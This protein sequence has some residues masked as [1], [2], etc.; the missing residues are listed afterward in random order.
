M[1]SAASCHSRVRRRRLAIEAAQAPST[2][3]QVAGQADAS[4]PLRIQLPPDDFDIDWTSSALGQLAPANQEDTQAPSM[5]RSDDETEEEVLHE[6]E[7]EEE[8]QPEPAPRRRLVVPQPVDDHSP[9]IATEC[10]RCGSRLCST[11]VYVVASAPFAGCFFSNN[12]D[13]PK[14]IARL[15]F[16]HTCYSKQQKTQC[17][18]KFLTRETGPL[19]PVQHDGI[20]FNAAQER[21]TYLYSK[22]QLALRVVIDH[23]SASSERHCDQLY[24]SATLQMLKTIAPW[25]IHKDLVICTGILNGTIAEWRSYPFGTPD[26]WRRTPVLHPTFNGPTAYATYL[27]HRRIALAFQRQGLVFSQF[28][29]PHLLDGGEIFYVIHMDATFKRAEM[30]EDLQYD[31]KPRLVNIGKFPPQELTPELLPGVYPPDVTCVCS[32]CFFPNCTF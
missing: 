15:P 3:P 11:C 19:P 29:S 18:F 20:Q 25:S 30:K 31:P 12:P 28:Y 22:D 5:Q 24:I 2:P 27:D 6:Q 32:M 4:S 16:K 26:C 23:L 1:E 9:V 10:R 7:E 13:L 14:N 21:K 17:T 8:V